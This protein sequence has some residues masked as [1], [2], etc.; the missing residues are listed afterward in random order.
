[1]LQIPNFEYLEYGNNASLPSGRLCLGDDEPPIAT[2]SAKS[3]NRPEQ[4]LL[5]Q[6]RAGDSLPS[7]ESSGSASESDNPDSVSYF[8]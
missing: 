5:L 7:P 4:K 3:R 1:M 8:L 6:R 2:M